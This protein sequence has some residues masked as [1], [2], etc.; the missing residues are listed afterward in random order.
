VIASIRGVR[1]DGRQRQNAFD[2]SERAIWSGSADAF[3]ATFAAVCAH[4]VPKLLDAL[5]VVAGDRLLDVG[6]GTGVVALAA[7][8]R[9]ATVTAVD[10]EPSMVAATSRQLEDAD[11]GV[12][13]LPALPFRDGAFDVVVANFVINHVGRPRDAVAELCRV[14]R[15]GGRV[16]V[17]LWPAEQPD[18]Q[19][20][21]VRAVRAAGVQ[22]PGDL[23][24]LEAADD[25]SRTP[26]GVSALLAEAGLTDV[27]CHA[28][29]WTHV[30]DPGVWWH[31]LAR[32]VGCYGHL[33]A[34][35]DATTIARVRRCFD[36][37]SAPFLAA[38]GRLHL[39]YAALLATGT[40]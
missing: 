17:T 11:V 40:R 10:A 5:E 16:G 35:Q 1:E 34:S 38:D 33:V 9:G 12:A 24:C 23:P 3:A 21:T 2:R 36:E 4:P 20:L 15:P 30:V 39:P 19:T 13:A 8:Q 27:E 32:G 26:A 29:G 37:L 18:G 31:G 7:S 6:T 22:R 28:L 14:A 25:F